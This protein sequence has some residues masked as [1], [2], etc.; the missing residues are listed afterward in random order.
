MLNP[1]FNIYNFHQLHLDNKKCNNGLTKGIKS[2]QHISNTR[3]QCLY[4]TGYQT[5]PLSA[6][7]MHD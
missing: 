5:I 4:V 3:H 2:I 1:N 6:I 7:E